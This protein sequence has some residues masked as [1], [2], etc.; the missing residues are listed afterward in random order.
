MCCFKQLNF[1]VIRHVAIGNGSRDILH[2]ITKSCLLV[3]EIL[4]QANYSN[5]EKNQNSGCLLGV[6]VGLTDKGHEESF[7]DDGNVFCSDAGLCDTGMC[8]C[9]HSNDFQD[10]CISLYVDFTS[11]TVNAKGFRGNWTDVFNLL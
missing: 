9:Q 3:C 10:L 1:A 2:C 11:K 5:V 4:L 8:L 6:E 7:W